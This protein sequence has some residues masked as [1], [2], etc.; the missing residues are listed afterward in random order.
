MIAVFWLV[1]PY[2]HAVLLFYVYICNFGTW[3]FLLGWSPLF[4]FS[5]TVLCDTQLKL[6]VREDA[7]IRKLQSQKARLSIRFQ[8]L[9]HNNYLHNFIWPQSLFRFH[10]FLNYMNMIWRVIYYLILGFWAYARWLW[11]NLCWATTKALR[12]HGLQ[13]TET[14]PRASLP[15]KHL[16]DPKGHSINLKLFRRI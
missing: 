8:T 3:D 4:V 6:H 9:L 5:L 15:P 16:K 2:I 13:K 7:L 14:R 11:W 10:Y 12:A 1:H